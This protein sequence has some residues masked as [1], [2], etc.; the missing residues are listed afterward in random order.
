MAH[1]IRIEGVV[2]KKYT[3][4]ETTQSVT[5][6][7]RP[8]G[9]LHA[10]VKGA[11]SLTSRRSPHLQTGNLITCEITQHVSGAWY[12]GSTTLHSA[13]S[14]LKESQD[15]VRVLY[16]ILLVLDRLLPVESPEDMIYEMLIRAM[17]HLDKMEVGHDRLL[18]TFVRDMC[19]ALGF[20]E[21]TIHSYDDV[22]DVVATVAEE[23]VRLVL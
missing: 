17:V 18:F 6:F 9:K 5:I 14:V 19:E 22:Q 1:S 13:F 11:R 21:Q 7:T 16:N 8:Y 15:K 20:G 10:I 12:L 23:Q 4:L 3:L 2:L